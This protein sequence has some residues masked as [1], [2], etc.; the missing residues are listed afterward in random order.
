M[1]GEHKE[2]EKLP[3]LFFHSFFFIVQTTALFCFVTTDSDT[4]SE[5]SAEHWKLKR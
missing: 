3:L 4:T 5:A 2:W 1:V